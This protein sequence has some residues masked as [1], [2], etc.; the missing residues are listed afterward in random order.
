MSSKASS[1]TLIAAMVFG[2][3]AHAGRIDF[4][5]TIKPEVDISQ[6]IQDIKDRKVSKVEDAIGLLPKAHKTNFTLMHDS[7]SVQRSTPEN[8][9]AILYGNTATSIF[10]FNG[11][12]SKQGYDAL[13]TVSIENNELIFRE[14]IFK[15]ESADSNSMLSEDDI[16]FEDERIIV[17]KGNPKKCMSC[18]GLSSQGRPIS[19]PRYLWNSYKEWPGA[20]GRQ[21]DDISLDRFY[22]KFKVFKKRAQNHPRYSQLNMF[23][24]ESDPYYHF[25][26]RVSR[27]LDKL[28]NGVFGILMAGNY[29]HVMAQKFSEKIKNDPELNAL[30]WKQKVVALCRLKLELF[31]QFEP[32]ENTKKLLASPQRLE[33]LH[34]Y[35]NEIGLDLSFEPLTRKNPSMEAVWNVGIISQVGIFFS[36]ELYGTFHYLLLR[37]VIPE[38]VI[39]GKN[40]IDSIYGVFS[41]EMMSHL[42]NYTS[43]S[44]GQGEYFD[45]EYEDFFKKTLCSYKLF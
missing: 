6:F 37:D 12:K 29:G 2:I 32:G 33:R 26:T 1:V 9:R 7:H 4:S 20:Y 21:D 44:L 19:N 17:S 28:K 39:E 42:L 14:I 31:N 43:F 22:E 45:K 11:D 8:P 41:E 24:T 35:L 27:T 34:Q 38:N 15:K 25:T 18:H 40:S 30:D 13:E 36:N 5:K 3:F 16:A 23:E 10:S